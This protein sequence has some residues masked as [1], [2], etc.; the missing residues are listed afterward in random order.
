VEEFTPGAGGVASAIT[1]EH[2][3][4]GI[5]ALVGTVNRL[6]ELG[7]DQLGERL[8]TVASRASYT[9][10]DHTRI[11]LLGVDESTAHR[12]ATNGRDQQRPRRNR[13]V[14]QQ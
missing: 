12:R 10:G 3:F 8:A 14:A 2:G 7:L 11:K 4:E 9:L 5:A 1:S 13:A 6:S